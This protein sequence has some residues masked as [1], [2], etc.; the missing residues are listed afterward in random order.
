MTIRSRDGA[1]PQHTGVVTRM[2]ATVRS[3]GPADR[4]AIADALLWAVNWAPDRR[5]LTRTEVLD[6][7]ALAHYVQGW[8]GPGDLGAVAESP[9][10]G[11]AVGAAWLRHLPASDPGYGFVADGVP[12]LSIGVHPGHRGRGI[13]RALLSAVLDAAGEAGIPRVSLS[14]ERGNRAADLYLA[15]GFRVVGGDAN[16]DTMLLD[17]RDPRRRE[18]DEVHD[19]GRRGGSAGC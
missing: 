5:P 9:T 6:A 7:P 11:D 3:A 1:A 10:G 14:V 4:D 16:S 19:H 2:A 13:G 8:P 18:C 15:E 12:E 17:L